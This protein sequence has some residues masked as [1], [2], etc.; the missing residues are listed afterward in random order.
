LE[1]VF[2]EFNDRKNEIQLYINFINLSENNSLIYNEVNKNGINKSE[3][4]RIF[5]AN[6]YLLL[7]NLVE[8]TIRN[9]IQEI[10]DHLN[11]K[12]VSFDVLKPNIKETILQG[13]KTKSP[14]KIVED[15]EN[16]A[17][18]IISISFDPD[19]I[20]NGNI[21]AKKIREI[22]RKYCFSDMTDYSKC[23]NGEKLLEIKNKRNNLSHG[24]VSFSECGREISI[25]DLNLAFNEAAS[26]LEGILENVK[27]YLNSEAYLFS[28]SA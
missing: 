11:L 8:S 15:I 14:I 17:A 24:I 13:L 9:T 21:D 12:S 5:L 4:R 19:K 20:S 23:K 18:D 26:Y 28:E 10:Y 6:A 2:I 22:A 7:Y 3:L 27:V 16:I 25:S 1:T